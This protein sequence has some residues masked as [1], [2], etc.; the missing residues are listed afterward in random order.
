LARAPARANSLNFELWRS[1][2]TV[3]TDNWQYKASG[4]ESISDEEI[5][6]AIRYLDPEA[7]PKPPDLTAFIALFAVCIILCA[8]W[9]SFHLRGW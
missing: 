3:W 2:H 7:R 4:Q 5:R 8:I 6:L 1:S 9:Y